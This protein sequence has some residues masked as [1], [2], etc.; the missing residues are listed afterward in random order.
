MD[1]LRVSAVLSTRAQFLLDDAAKGGHA[2][3]L[4]AGLTTVASLTNSVLCQSF[5]SQYTE[6]QT[7]EAQPLLPV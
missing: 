5:S 1:V 3:E 4:Q 7:T 6:A 2:G